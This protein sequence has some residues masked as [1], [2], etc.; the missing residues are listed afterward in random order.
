MNW[1]KTISIQLLIG[2][3]FFE[4]ISYIGSKLNLFI[5]NDTP[6][7]YLNETGSSAAESYHEGRTE[8]EVWGAWRQVNSITRQV[9]PCFDVEISTNE[10]GA[11]DTSFKQLNGDNLIL[12]GDSF[13]EGFGVSHTQT[14]EYLIEQSLGVNILNFGT[15]GNFGPL[16]EYLIYKNLAQDFAHKG[17]IIFVLPAND[18]TDNDKSFWDDSVSNR[19]RYRPYYSN[20][21]NPQ[22][23]FYFPEAKPT[24]I[25]GQYSGNEN[26]VITFSIGDIKRIIVKNFWLSNPLRSLSYLTTKQ[27][28]TSGSYYLSA[29]RKQ[30]YDMVGAY[31]EIVKAAS[32][33]PVSFVIIPTD[34][35]IMLLKNNMDTINSQYWYQSLK[36]LSASSG[37]VFIDLIKFSVSDSN[38]LFH[39][40]DGHWSALGNKWAAE[41]ISKE[42]S[43]FKNPKL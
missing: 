10:V 7:L 22:T 34:R 14:A 16:Q 17:V 27:D 2:L 25:F 5:V 6:A 9:R 13:A 36:D 28:V 24:D 35:D 29:S 18:F 23:P 41:I 26:N 8:R 31:S 32:G 38:S 20:L 40:C 19:I 30:Q 33:K 21:D 12:L 4:L 15:A 3:I 1:I 37:G 42:L 43:S 39:T 11:R